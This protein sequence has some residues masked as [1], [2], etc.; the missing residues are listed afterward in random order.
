MCGV[1]ERVCVGVSFVR[2]FSPLFGVHAIVESVRVNEVN[3]VY[4]AIPP[5]R[6]HLGSP[7]ARYP[8]VYRQYFVDSN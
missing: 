6:V 1:V 4:S 5:D 8:R 7:I 2:G 3:G